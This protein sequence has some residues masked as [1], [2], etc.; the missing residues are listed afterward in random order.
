MH[1][2]EESLCFSFL[3]F[4]DQTMEECIYTLYSYNE[5]FEPY[6]SEYTF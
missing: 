6:E 5:C 1:M 4:Y 2:P 3:Y